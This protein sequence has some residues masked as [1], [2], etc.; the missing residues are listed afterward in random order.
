PLRI[1]IIEDDEVIADLVK[2]GLEEAHF[3]VDV[4]YDGASGLQSALDGEYELIVLDV[5]LP[6]RDGWGVCAD[7]RARR[8]TTPILML[9]ARDAVED[10]VRGLESG[11]DDY[12]PKPFDFAELRA[13]VR[14]LL[15]RDRI[16]KSGVIRIADLELDTA[17]HR[18]WRAGEEI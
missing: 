16:Y 6:G 10:R 14:A 11:A 3:T 18:A 7:L 1:L 15:R 2:T 5:M 13:R 4:A 8:L 17:A 9:T 12:L